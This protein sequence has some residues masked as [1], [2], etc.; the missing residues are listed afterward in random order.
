LLALFGPS[1]SVRS[2]FQEVPLSVLWPLLTSG[3]SAIHPCMGCDEGSTAPFH[4]FSSRP[5]QVRAGNFHP[6]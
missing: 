4:H 2:V 6:R 5:P 3:R 1:R